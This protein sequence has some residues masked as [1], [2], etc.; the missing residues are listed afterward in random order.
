MPSASER[1]LQA[2]IASHM[3]W[4]KTPD[5]TAR[6]ANGRAAMDQKFLDQAGGDPIRAEH[7]R[8]AYY[9]RLALKSATARRKIKT[10]TVEIQTRQPEGLR[11]TSS[12][13]GSAGT[14][15]GRDDPD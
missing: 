7:F 1:R 3:S 4:A 8:Q 13:Q 5:R 2:Q 12:P 15:T 10:L 11:A 14:P 6:T 9:K